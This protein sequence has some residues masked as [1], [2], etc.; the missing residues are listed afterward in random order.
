MS[1]F[2][3]VPQD[4]CVAAELSLPWRGTHGPVKHQTTRTAL[5]TPP[6]EGGHDPPG[7]VT[8]EAFDSY[9]VSLSSPPPPLS[10]PPPC[11]LC[12]HAALQLK[13]QQRR[14]REEL[15]SQGIM[16]RKSTHPHLH[17]LSPSAIPSLT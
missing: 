9:V 14:T 2:G 13:L 12:I 11:S 17:R 1:L 3:C 4:K 8:R 16:P 15:V 5:V 10:S 6:S 7:A